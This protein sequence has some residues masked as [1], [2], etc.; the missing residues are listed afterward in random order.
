[1]TITIDIPNTMYRHLLRIAEEEYGNS[2]VETLSV[3]LQENW[4]DVLS[5][6]LQKRYAKRNANTDE[7]L[8]ILHGYA[9]DEEPQESDRIIQ[10]STKH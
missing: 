2:S 6:S 5:Q 8:Q 4:N 3:L 7:A 10:P 9:G 1:M